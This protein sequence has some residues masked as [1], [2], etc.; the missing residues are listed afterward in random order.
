MSLWQAAL[1]K[2]RIIDIAAPKQRGGAV[3]EL[4]LTG[5]DRDQ[6]ARGRAEDYRGTRW[7][8]ADI[9]RPL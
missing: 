3:P 6:W 7:G 9:D 5:P 2:H 1:I 4:S 8:R